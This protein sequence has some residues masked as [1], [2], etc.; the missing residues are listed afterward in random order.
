MA[1][2]IVFGGNGWLG[3]K[4]ALRFYNCGYDVTI[5]C[6]G[7]RS[8]FNERLTG[9]K[10]ITADKKN[11]EDMKNIFDNEI[12]SIVIDS[13]PTV[14]SIEY[15][16]KYARGIRHY[17]HCSS[18]GGYAP[19][20]FIPCNETALYNGFGET[21]GW[22]QKAIV[23]N[24]VMRL[25][26]VEGFPATVIRPCYI[27]GGADR[28]PLDNLGGRREDFLAD[29]LAEKVLDLPDNGL[30][31]LQPIHVD[32]LADSFLDAVLNRNSIGEIY[33]IVSD[34]AVTLNQYL[35]LNAFALGKKVNINY[36]PLEEMVKKYEGVCGEIGLRFLATHMCFTNTKA[37]NE[38]G[39][40]P[41]NN[42]EDTIIE[43]AQLC[44]AKLLK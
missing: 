18:T 6:R 36:V 22:V 28:L 20:P 35:E 24:E 38:I 29:I 1:K 37:R 19:L 44:A 2:V 8:E 16:F 11:P 40:I 41:A 25:F 30:S 39:F 10:V 3:H 13:V 21:K 42:P 23:D 27:T 31:L 43:T 33:N 26:Q 34:H 9:I 32:D 12:Y 17:L 14:E 5:A 15:I 7:N 4:I